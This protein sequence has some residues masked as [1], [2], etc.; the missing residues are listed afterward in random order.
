MQGTT[1]SLPSLWCSRLWQSSL[2][3]RQKNKGC[4]HN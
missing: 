4:Y 3:L 2:V 1:C